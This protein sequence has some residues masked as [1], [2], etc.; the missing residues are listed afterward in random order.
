MLP[1]QNYLNKKKNQWC[2]NSSLHMY[3]FTLEES[4]LSG[5]KGNC[6]KRSKMVPAAYLKFSGKNYFGNFSI[7]SQLIVVTTSKPVWATIFLWDIVTFSLLD[8]FI[9]MSRQNIL[10]ILFPWKI[11]HFLLL[12]NGMKAT[13]TSELTPVRI[14][15]AFS[16][17]VILKK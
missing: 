13:L 16:A 9:F 10:M 3:S 14:L 12:Y 11:F 7:Q 8:L 5:T 15:H 1:T 4:D 6:I 17:L 2:V